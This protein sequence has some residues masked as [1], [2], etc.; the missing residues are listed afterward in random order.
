MHL[1]TVYQTRVSV[2]FKKSFD[3]F[4]FLIANFFLQFLMG[5]FLVKHMGKTI[6]GEISMLFTMLN[7]ICPVL[8]LGTYYV[9]IEK[10]PKLISTN[11]KNQLQALL[12]WGLRSLFVTAITLS[13]ISL[14]F[15]LLQASNFIPCHTYFCGNSIKIYIDAVYL[16]PIFLITFWNSELFLA[17]KEQKLSVTL[18]PNNN[19][20]M[21]MVIIASLGYIYTKYTGHFKISDTTSFELLYATILI[22]LLAQYTCILLQKKHILH[23]SLTQWM[24]SK[25]Q[26]QQKQLRKIANTYILYDLIGTLIGLSIPVPIELAAPSTHTL[27]E[28]YICTIVGNFAMLLQQSL[29]PF[30]YEYLSRAGIDKGATEKLEKLFKQLVK[31]GIVW[32]II[33]IAVLLL[34]RNQ[35]LRFF[36]VH[37][38]QH[39]ISG[40]ILQ[41]VFVSIGKIVYRAELIL[42]YRD[43]MKPIYIAKCMQMVL[44]TTLCFVLVQKI[45]FIGAI[46]AN[47]AGKLCSSFI[48]YISLKKY[49][50]H[51][52][53]FGYI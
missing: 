27:A 50:I 15:I 23:C 48:C 16:T 36:H 24:W 52:K 41:M 49:K 38:T 46:L 26:K 31:S 35:I 6:Y 18:S 51:I 4:L 12:N 22:I 17:I 19:K 25:K 37:N 21:P 11:S 42:N 32:L 47:L 20:G 2:T 53:P 33:S 3:L 7:S 29:S 28:Y 34:F 10:T 30:M 44:Q 9:M 8:L 45:G 14:T 13:F 5:G 1:I 43:I 40:I 39:M